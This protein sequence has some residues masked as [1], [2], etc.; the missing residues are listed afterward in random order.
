MVSMPC[1]ELFDAQDR[2]YRDTV[3]PPSV[4]SRVAVEA[5]HGD[6]WYKYV[7]I[8]GAV[9]AMSTFGA[10]A[11]AAALYDYFGITEQKVIEAVETLL[12]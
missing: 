5:G 1:T 2:A 11:P 10:S 9:V 7:G 8:D 3:L 12:A 6:Y 4:R